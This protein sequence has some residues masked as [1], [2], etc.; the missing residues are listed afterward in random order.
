MSFF[1]RIKK[2]FRPARAVVLMYHRVAEPVMDPWQLAVSTQNFKEHLEVLAETGKVISTDQLIENVISRSLESDCYCVTS[3]DAYE[4]NY[5]NALPVIERLKCPTTFFI[6]SGHIGSGQPFWWDIMT[7]IFLSSKKL[8]PTLDININNKRFSYILENDGAVDDEKLKKHASWHWPLPA[9]TQRCKIYLELWMELRDL[10]SNVISETVARLKSW[11]G[12][13]AENK[14]GN[15]P[16]ST[17]QLIEM[18][19]SQYVNTGVHTVTHA[20]LG[21]FQK[22]IQLSEIVE[23]K[24]YLDEVLKRKHFSI[25]YPYGNYNSDTLDIAKESGLKGAFTTEPQAVTVRSDIYR[26]G[27]F[28]V[29]N[30]SGA[31]FRKQLAKWKNN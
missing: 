1:T 13:E 23:C 21:A 15:F 17:E 31:Q 9:P 5:I 14:S 6:A 16:M 20:A 19:R 18:C 10:P 24:R 22:N 8:P 12:V 26:L 29:V 11:S 2:M 30:Q 25:A 27:R 7:D 4:D 28:Q 3:D